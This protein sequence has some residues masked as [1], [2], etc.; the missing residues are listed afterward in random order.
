M[1]NAQQLLIGSGV[2]RASLQDLVAGELSQV[3]PSDA[4]F[5]IEGPRIWLDERQTQS[6]GLT[7]HELATNSAKY[8][9]A[10]MV[11]AGVSVRWRV[12][13]GLVKLQWLEQVGG[14]AQV[15]GPSGF[16]SKLLR[17]LVVGELGGTLER[18]LEKEQLRI[19]IIF[20]LRENE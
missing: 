20:P 14:A 2:G 6:L 17:T 19:E 12:E 10:S 11:E 8:G 4:L 18:H 15:D 3:F 7:F 1:A 5:S 13:D 9:A 16:G